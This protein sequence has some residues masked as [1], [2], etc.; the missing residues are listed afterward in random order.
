[1]AELVTELEQL[2]AGLMLD[3]ELV[4]F[5]RD[6]RPSFERLGQRMLMR[7]R[8]IPVYFVAFDLLAIDGVSTLEQPY[9]ER[10]AILEAIDYGG[11]CWATVPAFDDGQALWHVVTEQRLEGVVAKPLESRYVPGDRRLWVKTKS[12]AWPRREPEREAVARA[13]ERQRRLR[14]QPG[15]SRTLPAT[16]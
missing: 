6:G 13:R 15:M 7:R 8:D 16:R 2:P 12:A 3:G 4:S 1:M 9:V 11:P 10:R 14:V 5:D